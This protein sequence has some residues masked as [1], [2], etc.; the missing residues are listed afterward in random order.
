MQELLKKHEFDRDFVRDYANAAWAY[1]PY[2]Y[3]KAE[4]ANLWDNKQM[5]GAV[6]RLIDAAAGVNF[7]EFKAGA[8]EV[9]D[10]L[11]QRPLRDPDR[12][13]RVEYDMRRDTL[14]ADPSLPIPSTVYKPQQ[15]FHYRHDV[16]GKRHVDTHLPSDNAEPQDKS[17]AETVGRN[18]DA[19]R[20]AASGWQALAKSRVSAQED[21]TVPPGATRH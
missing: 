1:T 7:G 11:W 6:D 12:R 21:I 20:A 8:A 3:A 17:F 10:T 9:W 4:F 15:R 2:M 13:L 16:L 14:P 19:A 18:A 5:D